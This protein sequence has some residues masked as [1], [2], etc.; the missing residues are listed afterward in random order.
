MK[1]A[2]I[3][4]LTVLFSVTGYSFERE[5]VWPKGKMPDQQAHQIA[6]MTDETSLPDFDPDKH[7]M[8]YLEWFDAP[9]PEVR[10]GGCMILISGGSYKN[11]CDVGLIKLWRETFTALGF[12][13]VNFV[14]RTSRPIGLPIYQSAWEDGQR[15]VR[16]VRKEAKKRGY[17]PEKIGVIGMSAGSHLTL[18]LATSSQTPAYQRIDKT[19]LITILIKHK[20]TC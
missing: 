15:A 5:P 19:D 1:K 3:F 2:I 13:C 10:N 4:L 18:L 9:S 11:C 14:Y 12:Q 20:W 8:P 7:R 17:D 6:A 16:L